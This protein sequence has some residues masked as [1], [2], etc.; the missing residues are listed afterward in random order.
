MTRT[1][2]VDVPVL[3]R[4]EGEGALH[5]RVRD[6]AVEQVQL[7]I[8]EPPRFFEGLLQGRSAREAPDITARICGIC[9]VAYQITACNAVE[10]AWG[11]AVPEP[12]RLMRR[13][14]YCGEW[15]QSHALHVY[16]LHAPDLLGYPDAIAMAADHRDLVEQ[17]LRLK[18][19]GNDLMRLVGGRAVHP[20]TVRVGGFWR[21]PDAAD[22]AAVR[23]TLARALDDAVATVRTVAALDLPDLQVPYHFVALQPERAGDYPLE[24]GRVVLSGDGVALPQQV[25]LAQFDQHVHEVQVEHSHALQARLHDGGRYLVGPLARWALLGERL[26]GAAGT[27][28]AEVALPRPLLN[29][30]ASIVVRALEVVYAVEEALRIVDAWPADAGQAGVDAAPRAGVGIG[31]SEAP[32]GLLVH[33]YELDQAGDVL[34]AAIVP[35][36]SQNQ[37]QIEDDLRRL[38]ERHLD[39]D[40]EALR[41]RCETAVRNHDP[42][43]SCATHAIRLRVDRG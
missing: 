11:L 22:L 37:A 18:K 40:D 31:A 17:G 5:L 16:L 23:P 39:L 26:G 36:T 6:G 27:L 30:F 7:H 3:A 8:Y 1:R 2:S 10:D 14:L 35:P 41:L 28:A 29:P 21:F 24:S 34:R 9:P 4:V 42:C 15:V 32:R 33:R 25:D 20:V 43:I 38:V 19:A 12:V 13:L